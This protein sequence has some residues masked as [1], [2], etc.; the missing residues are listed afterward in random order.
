MGKVLHQRHDDKRTGTIKRWYK[1]RKEDCSPIS[2][3]SRFIR[4]S[5]NKEEILLQWQSAL[6]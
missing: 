6:K 3:V 4:E 1:E 2:E 5:F